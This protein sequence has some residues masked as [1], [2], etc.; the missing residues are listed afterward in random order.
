MVSALFGVI[1]TVGTAAK[2]IRDNRKDKEYNSDGTMLS[3]TTVSK[4][5]TIIALSV[6]LG[7]F[8][9]AFLHNGDVMLIIFIFAFIAVIV[10]YLE[11]LGT[12]INSD[13]NG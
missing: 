11:S 9:I 1:L 8:I 10:F 7:M 5:N 3:E 12:Y 2:F 6:V 13:K 4:I